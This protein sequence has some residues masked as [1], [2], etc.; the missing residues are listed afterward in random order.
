MRGHEVQPHNCGESEGALNERFGSGVEEGVPV[1]DAAHVKDS[2][3]LV[4]RLE[5][6]HWKV[7][8]LGLP[9]V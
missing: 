7:E 8:M 5:S 9:W 2:Y 3:T 6:S 4:S 1:V